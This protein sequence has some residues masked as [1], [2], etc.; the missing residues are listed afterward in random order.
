MT[1]C[2]GITLT[3]RARLLPADMETPISLFMGMVGAGDGILLESAAVDGKW[4][5]YSILACDILLRIFCRDGELRLA[6]EDDRLAF[7]QELEGMP[8]VQ[9]LKS[10]MALITIEAPKEEGLDLPPITRALYG[11]LGFEMA[12]LFNP[13]LAK[14]LPREEAEC[15]LVLPGT[16]LVFDHVYNRLCQLSLGSFR[17]IRSAHEAGFFGAEKNEASILAE[18][19]EEGFKDYVRRIQEELRQGEGIQCVPSVRFSIPFRGDSFAHYRR[20]R[21]INASPYLFYM[22]FPS[23]SLFGSSPEVMVRCEKN[24][25]LLSPIAGTRRRGHD[26]FEDHKLELELLADPKERA[27]HVMLVDLGRNDLGRVAVKGSVQVERLMQIERFSHVM[28]LTSSVTADLREGLDAVDVL[29][30]TFPAG[31]VSGAPK[32]RAIEMLREMEG[33]ARGPY[34]GSVG[35]I[36]LDHDSVNLDM[37]ITIRSMWTRQGRLFWQAGA[38]IVHDSVPELEWKE[39]NNK[40][41]IMRLVLNSQEEAD[42][43]PAHR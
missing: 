32:L 42:H 7:L 39:V 16:V 29:S 2:Q 26:A 13:K 20:M 5:R 15:Q 25:L 21:R 1:Q 34:A 17:E 14:V 11:Y 18:P 40:S 8:F 37:G 31:T 35:W 23:L 36:G 9:G 10:L 33:R 27:E 3:Q 19:G 4:G 30:A 24:K 38:G 41:A 22:H 43:V 12:G 6:I 28:H